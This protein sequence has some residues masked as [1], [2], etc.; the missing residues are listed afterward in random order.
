M[1]R[2]NQLNPAE[3]MNV[4][5]DL[6]R[7]LTAALDDE[8]E[9]AK[10]ESDTDEPFEHNHDDQP[11]PSAT[12]ISP[13]DSANLGSRVTSVDEGLGTSR[14]G[15]HTPLLTYNN[16][17]IAG[18]NAETASSTAPDILSSPGS[19]T[20]LIGQIPQDVI[21]Q[22]LIIMWRSIQQDRAPSAH[23]HENL[24]RRA[25]E[26]SAEQWSRR[27]Q[28]EIHAAAARSATVLTVQDI[29]NDP[30]IGSTSLSSWQTQMHI[31]GKSERRSAREVQAEIE[32]L[33]TRYRDLQVKQ[34]YKWMSGDGGRSK[35]KLTRWRQAELQAYRASGSRVD[36]STHL[37][38]TNKP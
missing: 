22:S 28:R 30:T 15:Y 34:G 36:S 21:S 6:D 12:Q 8:E 29:I 1:S 24:R 35:T 26:R 11:V 4:P 27:T 25:F 7:P 17:T 5:V 13:I 23:T 38:Y 9:R 20:D 31:R 16:H 3:L 33:E 18:V 14:L 32:Y 19:E 10:D 2:S 37:R